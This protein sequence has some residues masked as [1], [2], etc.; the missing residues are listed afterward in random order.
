MWDGGNDLRR[1][2]E[3]PGFRA[4]FLRGFETVDLATDMLQRLYA[5]DRGE[6]RVGGVACDFQ[7]ADRGERTGVGPGRLRNGPFELV[8]AE[9]RADLRPGA[10]IQR[11]EAVAP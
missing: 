11:V 3:Q 6:Q 8:A 1:L 2:Q 10:K 4:H 7:M 5:L 9:R